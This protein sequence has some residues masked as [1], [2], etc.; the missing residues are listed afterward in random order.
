MKLISRPLQG[1]PAAV[2]R[3]IVQVACT[4]VIIILHPAL[5]PEL[6]TMTVTSKFKSTVIT[7]VY[8]NVDDDIKGVPPRRRQ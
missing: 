8:L 3:G 4:L 6:M 2:D 1:L 5:N 7:C